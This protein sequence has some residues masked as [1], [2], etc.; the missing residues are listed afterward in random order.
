[1]SD[2]LDSRIRQLVGEIRGEAGSPATWDEVTV[3]R[4][5]N[6]GD[7]R[8]GFV[9][10]AA[11]AL[12]AIGL[13]AVVL[14]AERGGDA[15][16][17]TDSASDIT[18]GPQTAI[19]VPA[20]ESI[21]PT[22]SSPSTSDA[23]PDTSSS[24]TT[25]AVAAPSDPAFWAMPQQQL[26][27]TSTTFVANVVRLGCNGGV[28]GEVFEPEIVIDDSRIVITFTVESAPAGR[29]PT[30]DAVPY[31]VDIGQPIGDRQ[32]V[33][34]ACL[35]GGAA[36]STM[37]CG[38]DGVRWKAPPP[39][40]YEPGID[41]IRSSL[42]GLPGV[43]FADPDEVIDNVPDSIG[44]VTWDTGWLSM[45]VEFACT[46]NDSFRTLWWGDV[47]L[48]FETGPDGTMLTAWSIGDPAVSSLAP[49][50]PLPPEVDRRASGVV[51][52]EGIGIGTPADDVRSALGD[53]IVVDEPNHLVVLGAL[54]TQVLLDDDQRVSS[55]GSGRND[56]ID[57]ENV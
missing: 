36:A 23:R 30:N 6:G 13:G 32:L 29:C 41:L 14:V 48:T 2:R 40:V 5:P 50:G 35:P 51:S 9:V 31:V 34:G 4:P 46:G 7:H 27:S 11:V 52:N 22:A 45:P 10:V 43:T 25:A 19:I 38:P 55:I 49:L 8:R 16:A 28:T 17:P 54:V 53:D 12:A 21:P 42:F 3:V 18:T 15:N 24:P 37:W 44:D 20:L 47:R 33:D 1:M 39:I 26:D 57:G 56:C